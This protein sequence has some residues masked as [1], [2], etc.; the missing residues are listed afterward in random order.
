MH[1]AAPLVSRIL[2][3]GPPLTQDPLVTQASLLW[4]KFTGVEGPSAVG[5]L[6]RQ[7]SWDAPVVKAAF[8]TLLASAPDDYSRARLRAAAS[9]HAGDRLIN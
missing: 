5:D 6:S 3:G 2:S 4:S 9:P 8:E 7:K 1:G